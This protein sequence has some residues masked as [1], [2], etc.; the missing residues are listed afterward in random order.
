[1]NKGLDAVLAALQPI[2]DQFGEGLS[3]ADLIVLAGG[4]GLEQVSIYIVY[5][6]YIVYICVCHTLL[7]IVFAFVITFRIHSMGFPSE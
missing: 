5:I 1:M 3:W 4:V 7:S 6:L 2:K